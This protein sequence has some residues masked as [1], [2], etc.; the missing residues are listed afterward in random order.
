MMERELARIPSAQAQ[1]VN[2]P[3]RPDHASDLYRMLRPWIFRLDP[4]QAHQVT[5]TLLRLAGGTLPGR[6]AMS[7]LFPAVKTARPVHV[8]GLDFPNPVGLAAG[9]DKDAHAW[10]GLALLGFGHIEIGTITPRPQ[11]GNPSPRIFRLVEDQ[12][13]VNRMGFPNAGALAVAGRLRARRPRG[14]VLGVSIGKNKSTPAEDVIED[15][16]MGMR[17]FAPLADYLAVNVSSPN[18]PGLR[19][20][21]KYSALYDLLAALAVER[22]AL[23]AALGK[24]FP[25]LIKLAPDM[26]LNDLDRAV[27]AVQETGMDG[28]ILANTSVHRKRLVSSQAAEVGGLSGAPL[29]DHT[30]AMIETAERCTG[31]KLPIVASG[32]VMGPSDAQRMLEAGACLV[33]LY[34]G[35]IYGGP[36]LV[37]KI[38]AE[39]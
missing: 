32:G 15:Y 3:D 6:I 4:E 33:Q 35:L 13:V 37:R 31:G 9:Y 14:L 26:T 10:R 34:T 12:A 36:G 25:V 24:P 18:T 27:C 11:P 39:V 20:L 28:I 30:V 22:Q 7:A 16:R 2:R 1:S 19:E 29:V 38:V 21:Q 8:F 5:L 17:T 23:R